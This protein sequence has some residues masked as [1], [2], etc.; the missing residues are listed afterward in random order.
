VFIDESGDAGI[1]TVRQPNRPGSSEYF[2]MAAAV[3]QRATV[4]H[5]GKE[6]SRLQ[7]EFG[8]KKRWKHATE[9]NHAQRVHLCKTLSEMNIRFFGVIS[10]K[11]TLRDYAAEI[12]WEPDKFYNKCAKYLLERVG[13]YLGHFGGSM[14]EPR[15]V[16]EKRNHNY[17]AMIRYL[18]S[19][20]ENPIYPQSKHL[21]SVNPFGITSRSKSEED[22]LRVADAASHAIYSCVNK[23]PDN[24]GNPEPRYLRELTSRFGADESGKVLGHGLKCIHSLSELELDH[25]IAE[26]ITKMRAVPRPKI[27]F[28]RSSLG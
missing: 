22:M 14:L 24:F 23:T 1:S 4:I 25:D 9:L 12:S 21:V 2:V 11:S 19:V 10:R 8:K 17:D 27:I 6:L 5:A 15:I 28:P 3:M 13:E 16:F 18:N 7:L 26:T 20:K